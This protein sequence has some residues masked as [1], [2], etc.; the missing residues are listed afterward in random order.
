[1]S[2]FGTLFQTKVCQNRNSSKQLQRRFSLRIRE[3][4][5]HKKVWNRKWKIRYNLCLAFLLLCLIYCR[6]HVWGFDQKEE[7]GFFIFLNF[8]SYLFCAFSFLGSR[9]CSLI[10]LENSAIA[11]LGNFGASRI[12]QHSLLPFM[13]KPLFHTGSS[14]WFKPGKM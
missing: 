9:N 11:S 8:H 5:N 14:L 13:V 2:S 6:Y 4:N 1:M 7:F 12:L 10:L 3:Q